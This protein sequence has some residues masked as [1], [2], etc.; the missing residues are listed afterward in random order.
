MILDNNW[1]EEVAEHIAEEMTLHLLDVANPNSDNDLCGCL[2]CLSKLAIDIV[3][4]ALNQQADEM[5]LKDMHDK[6]IKNNNL[7]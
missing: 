1:R 6:N 2:T 5:M 7:N 3:L 4:D